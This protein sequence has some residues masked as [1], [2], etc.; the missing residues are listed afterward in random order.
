MVN[1]LDMGSWSLVV[2]IMILQGDREH[3]LETPSTE[4]SFSWETN[5]IAYRD[6]EKKEVYPQSNGMVVRREVVIL[7]WGPL[8]SRGAVKE[9]K[10]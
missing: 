10:V 1:V 9:D 3:R 4:D 2:Q 7:V 6:R 5:C 8:F